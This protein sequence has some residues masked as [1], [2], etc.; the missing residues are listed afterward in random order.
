[1]NTHLQILNGCP[2]NHHY[3]LILEKDGS[4]C[5]INAQWQAALRT[6]VKPGSVY[7]LMDDSCASK[8]KELM[9]RISDREGKEASVKL[10]FSNFLGK[11]DAFEVKFY[12]FSNNGR[13][14]I[15]MQ[16]F[17][18]TDQ[19]R[20][21][22][23]LLFE[24]ENSPDVSY[25]LDIKNKRYNYVSPAC[26]EVF[27]L[28]PEQAL[29][30]RPGALDY[31]VHPEDYNN[32]HTHFRNICKQYGSGKK[33]FFIRYR[34]FHSTKGLRWVI[35]RHTVFYNPKSEPFL[36][37][38]NIRDITDAHTA[39]EKSIQ[40][41]KLFKG[42]IE[43]SF[44]IVSL[45]DRYGTIKFVNPSV[46]PI[47]GL[48]PE[49]IINKNS[50]SI[51]P[52]YVHDEVK[53]TLEEV[54]RHP[55]KMV[56]SEICLQNQT[57]DWVYLKSKFAN[58]LDEP[59]IQF[60]LGSTQDITAQKR[61]EQQL[62]DS[63]ANLNI[64]INNTDDPIWSVD[65]DL[66]LIV[67]NQAFAGMIQQFFGFKPEIGQA[68]FDAIVAHGHP[69]Q[70][71][72]RNHFLQAL[73][74][75]KIR[76]ERV[77]E[78]ENRHVYMDYFISPLV[79]AEGEVTGVTCYGR[80]ITD[81]VLMFHRLEE[82]NE[83]LRKMN[84]DLDRFVYSMS[85]DLRSPVASALGLIQIMELETEDTDSLKHVHMIKKRLNRLDA[86][87]ADIL[88][89]SKQRKDEFLPEPVN[90]FELIEEVMET[91]FYKDE[92]PGLDLSVDF[93]AD[94]PVCTDRGRLTK[95]L[96]NLISNAVKYR[97]NAKANLS[98]KISGYSNLQETVIQV[99]DNG[100]G[101]ADKHKEKIFDMF[102]RATNLSKGS[103]L[104]LYI[105]KECLDSMQGSIQ[106]ESTLLEGSV[107]TVRFKNH[108]N[109]DLVKQLNE[110]DKNHLDY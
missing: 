53:R 43:N 88:E 94:F 110:S 74:G 21:S 65:K 46:E 101:I 36:L 44:E 37:L 2:F 78:F 87:I 73:T 41:E 34:I 16:F 103:G 64:I 5:F 10:T 93:S 55:E 106:V 104:G 14:K 39:Y 95:V 27:E 3:L 58:Y 97:D 72:C 59:H 25:E 67:F 92:L 85:H 7:E 18:I 48:K 98:I 31:K 81:K 82:Q 22:E 35:D 66:R 12:S 91:H 96:E 62:K 51:L 33:N 61:Y 79:N 83:A 52:A 29:Q 19:I 77:Y 32:V 56:E 99:K 57:G 107:F 60:I 1:M 102:F 70:S 4:I 28:T 49:E 71:E 8:V 89:F 42:I 11:D 80:N 105:V 68:V 40:N 9:T 26:F 38:G 76:F 84:Y 69:D 90:L 6:E 23:R 100:I 86:L 45:I 20:L 15:L 30:T 17:D 13:I 109:L 47:L 54:L 50:F 63:S 24:F 75:L 108:F